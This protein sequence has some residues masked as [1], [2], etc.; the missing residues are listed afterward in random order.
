MGA[1]PAWLSRDGLGMPRLVSLRLQPGK[2]EH[3]N[4]GC[5][6]RPLLNSCCSLV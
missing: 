1:G 3:C 6:L 2:D 5:V 4:C